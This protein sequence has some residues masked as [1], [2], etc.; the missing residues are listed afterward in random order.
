MPYNALYL[1]CVQYRLNWPG[2]GVKDG[3]IIFL[4]VFSTASQTSA[5]KVSIYLPS[6]VFRIGPGVGVGAGVGVDQEPGVGAGVIVGT[7]P[8]RLRI[9][10][11][12][13]RNGCFINYAKFQ[14]DPPSGSAAISEKVLGASPP[15]P[16][17]VRGVNTVSDGKLSYN[18]MDKR[19]SNG[20]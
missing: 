20:L 15:H 9:P 7:A 3:T 19:L 6:P 17:P 8:P 16:M 18:Q 11:Q 14:S 1:E 4:F 10:G 12:K 5:K 2:K 13:W